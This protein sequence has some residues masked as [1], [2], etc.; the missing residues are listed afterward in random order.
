M[1]HFQPLTVT[2]KVA[3]NRPPKFTNKLLTSPNKEAYLLQPFLMI[4]ATI[5]FWYSEFIADHLHRIWPRHFYNSA[6]VYFLPGLAL[7]VMPISHAPDEAAAFRYVRQHTTIPVPRVYASADGHGFRYFLMEKAKGRTM[8]FAWKSLDDQQRDAI[9]G[10][11]RDYIAQLRSLP[12]PF[13][14]RVCSASGGPLWDVRITCTQL[15]GPFEDEAHFNDSLIEWAEAFILRD[16][17]ATIRQRMR[18]D[19]RIHF[20]HGD[21][22]PRN[23]LVS[24]GRIS[25]IV[26]WGNSGWYPEHWELVKA[27]WCPSLGKSWDDRVTEIFGEEDKR[28]WMIDRE[29][30][31]H[32]VGV[33]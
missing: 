7:K 27:M 20:T 30:S 11:L 17:L 8:A 12:S 3:G 13:G 21:L 6:G 19:H 1:L 31:D 16:T 28:D 32:F 18:D 14:K 24:D 22:A 5:F 29:M 33:F 4:L 23:I 25:S 2:A 10:Q 9:V 26:D 15:V